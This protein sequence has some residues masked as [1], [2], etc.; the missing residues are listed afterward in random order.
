MG[1]YFLFFFVSGFCS[2][3]YEIIWLRLAM[4]QFGVTSALVSIVISMFMAG[5]GLGSWASGRLLRRY[6][7][8]IGFA[9]LRIY[10]GAELL[11]G[12][13]AL[14]VPRQLLWGR[15]LLEHASLSSSAAYY[16][17]SGI[18]I[19]ATLI[20][21][22]ACMGATIPV[23]MQAIRKAFEGESQKSFSFLYLANVL[24]AAAGATLPL[25]LIELYG[26]H[27]ALKV[28]AALNLSLAL[29]ALGFSFRNPQPAPSNEAP[30][31]CPFDRKATPGASSSVLV[32]LFATGL[33]S[34]G[35][36]VVWIRQ[37]TPYLGTVVYAFASILGLY[38]VSTFLG[39]HFYRSWSRTHVNEARHE[40]R[41]I[42]LLLG[43]FALLPLITADPQF[44][45][46]RLLR[47][48]IGICPFSAVLGF[49][50]P[51]LVDRWSG[52]DPDL[53]GR[54]Y[55]VNVIG[56]IIGPLLSGFLLLPLIS[57]RWVL[58]VLA[59]PWIVIGGYRVRASSGQAISKNKLDPKKISYGVG[60]LALLIIFFSKGYEDQFPQHVVLRDNTATVIATGE[61]MDKKLFVNG[62]G[63]TS[64]TPIT[65]MMAHLPLTFLDHAPKSTL[66]ICFGMGTTY[67]SLLSW[68]I[69]STA[70]ELAPS[71]ARVFWYFHPDGPEL[72]RSPL[73]HLVIDDGRRYLERTPARYDVITIDPPPPVEAAGSSMLYS[74]EFYSIIT[75]RL[76]PGG[77]LQQWLPEGDRAVRASVARALK[78]SF[79]Y[80]RLFQYGPDWGFHFLASNSPIPNRTPA[81][82]AQ[83]LP[84]KAAKDLVEWTPDETPEEVFAEI[85]GGETSVDQ[86]IAQDPQAPAMQ[87][88]R[89]VNEYYVLRR[90]LP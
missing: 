55:A 4:A 70:V 29:A 27:G 79:T 23:A 19:A 22:C 8:R 83:G 65:K 24:G 72:L 53:A 18:W 81:Q 45:M 52:G 60:A 16:L 58:S 3:L 61:G 46:S 62:V 36:E 56:C 51:M 39:S 87:D 17:A 26:F 31:S 2:I 63:I 68:G 88:N 85:I 59:L 40:G 21:W 9:A 11:I 64:L 75:Q 20:P 50:T 15:H 76:Q 74:K 84:P 33:T 78:E 30:P 44:E 41:M 71:V 14:T 66:T 89:P 73:S 82:L 13:A 80:V 6:G 47:L 35:M 12:V 7:D 10:A 86:F 54:A 57:E 5:L 34:M 32:L 48:L 90:Q 43:F 49:V 1:W 25:L 28:G 38:L 77:I 69:P 37:F 42:W 67:R